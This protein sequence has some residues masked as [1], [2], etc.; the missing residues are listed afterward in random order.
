MLERL[1]QIE[2]EKA[3]RKIGII[4]IPLDK[5]FEYNG[6]HYEVAKI[7]G[8]R[9]YY[10]VYCYETRKNLATRASINTCINKI[11]NNK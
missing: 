11:L 4:E 7:I 8:G 3:A 6:K 1:E 2:L 10:S 9:N 5:K